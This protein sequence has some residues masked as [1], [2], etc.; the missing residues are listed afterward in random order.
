MY[1]QC[2]YL[3]FLFVSVTLHVLLFILRTMGLLQAA[4]LP[5]CA[6]AMNEN[7]RVHSYTRST[8]PLMHH[9]Q[10]PSHRTAHCRALALLMAYTTSLALAWNFQIK[11]TGT[12][13][14]YVP[15]HLFPADRWCCATVTVFPS[16]RFSSQAGVD[17]IHNE[18][19]I[20]SDGCSSSPSS[21]HP[22][23]REA[24]ARP[25]K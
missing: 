3:H 21:A 9:L 11:S 6:E 16:Q 17:C 20:D 8:F 7:R 15:L 2:F 23:S 1:V 22:G 19:A 24:H 5:R 14:V 10:I 4:S 25:S 13:V 18:P 12:S